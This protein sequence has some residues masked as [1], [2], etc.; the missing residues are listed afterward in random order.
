MSQPQENTEAQALQLPRSERAEIALHL[1]DS[2]E[3]E[4]S[5]SSRDA[6]ERAWIE[7]SAHQ[8]VP[9]WQSQ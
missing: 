6:I 8:P 9:F 2:L 3:Q 4:Q 1:L 5:P 7:E